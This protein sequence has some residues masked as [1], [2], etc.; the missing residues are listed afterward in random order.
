MAKVLIVEDDESLRDVYKEIFE[1]E[2]FTVEIA[3]NGV[4]GIAKVR[5]F[6]PDAV[7]L[8]IVMPK[9]SGFDVLKAM[10]E[11]DKLKK[12][13]VVIITNVYADSQDLIQNWGVSFVLLKTDYTPGQIVQ[14]VKFAM[15]G[16]AGGS[17]G[18]I[19][20]DV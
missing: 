2:G 11:D 8:D 12:V 10:R 3:N 16:K 20:N 18:P 19:W 13:P 9:M 17:S 1:K 6:V 14:K 5:E 4:E 7:I 15:E